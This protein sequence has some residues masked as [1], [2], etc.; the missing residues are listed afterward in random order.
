ME[1]LSKGVCG[2]PGAK[3]AAGNHKALIAPHYLNRCDNITLLYLT[4]CGGVLSGLE[5]VIRKKRKWRKRKKRSG[6][7]GGRMLQLIHLHV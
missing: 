2:I 5:E 6:G 7:R 3:L 4:S 1:R